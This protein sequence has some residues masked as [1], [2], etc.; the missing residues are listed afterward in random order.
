MRFKG[1]KGDQEQTGS[2]RPRTRTELRGSKSFFMVD[3]GAVG[4]MVQFTS[5]LTSLPDYAPPSAYRIGK[6]VRL[7]RYDRAFRP[8]KGLAAKSG[9]NL[10]K[11]DVH[12]WRI[13]RATT[14]AAGGDISEYIET[15]DSERKKVG[16]RRV[17]GVYA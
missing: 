7:V 1:H 11:F 4:L 16:V 9:R 14:L 2:I 15:S 17:Q 12:S 6:S 3:G 5:C 8:I 10:D 13:G